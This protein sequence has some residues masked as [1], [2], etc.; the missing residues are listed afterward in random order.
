[1]NTQAYKLDLEYF[2]YF[3][4]MSSKL[5]VMILSY[6]ISKLA[7]FFGDS[8]DILSDLN[9]ILFINEAVKLH[10]GTGQ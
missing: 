10:Y 8:V 6:S 7:H 1:M 4:Q 3:C 9:M 2:E 5:I